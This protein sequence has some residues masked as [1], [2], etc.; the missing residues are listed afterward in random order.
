MKGGNSIAHTMNFKCPKLSE[1]RL[2]LDGNWIHINM[3]T[4]AIMIQSAECRADSQFMAAVFDES[5]ILPTDPGKPL[6][7]LA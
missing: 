5:G 6:P 3:I 7:L 1:K 4:M 2:V